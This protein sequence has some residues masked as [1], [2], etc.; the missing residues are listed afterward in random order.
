[1]ACNTSFV[2][3]TPGQW[4]SVAEYRRGRKAL[5]IELLGGAVVLSITKNAPTVATIYGDAPAGFL[6]DVPTASTPAIFTITLQ[7][8]GDMVEQE[9]FAWIIPASL[10][11]VTSGTITFSANDTWT[12]PP[13][14]T[15]ADIE[16]HGAGGGTFDANS[17]DGPTAGGGGG[18]WALNS[19][20]PL[21]AGQVYTI[22]VDP[23]TP[24]NPGADPVD[25]WLSSTGIAPLDITEGVMAKSGTNAANFPANTPGIGGSIAGSIGTNMVAGSDG[26]SVPPFVPLDVMT[27]G[28]GGGAGS[29]IG[30][31]TP[32]GNGIVGGSTGATGGINGGGDAG[33]SDSTFGTDGEAG[34]SGGGGGGGSICDGT[35]D[36][37]GSGSTGASLTITWTGITTP[38]LTILESYTVPAFDDPNYQ[39]EHGIFEVPLPALTP[40]GV[41]H[42]HR[43]MAKINQQSEASNVQQ[44]TPEHDR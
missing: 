36:G 5:F 16:A 8:N 25:T 9:W 17:V 15:T 6:L 13:G 30:F 43:L 39:S 42:L 4:V 35:H 12:A 41:K 32:G 11:P 40:E 18:A 2:A 20:F 44:D 27:G 22:Q 1:M 19:P 7:D 29:V 24:A 38:I 28:G 3:A 10:I 23:G 26:G 34:T 21:V 31:S 33:R 37:L 14:V